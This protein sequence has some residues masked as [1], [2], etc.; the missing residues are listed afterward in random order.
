[1]HLLV[2]GQPTTFL[3]YNGGVCMPPLCP[4]PTPALH[5]AGGCPFYFSNVAPVP[6]PGCFMV[7][8]IGKAGSW[9]STQ[10]SRWV[11]SLEAAKLWAPVGAVRIANS[12]D[13]RKIC[14][15]LDTDGTRHKLGRGTPGGAS[16]CATADTPPA[17][18]VE[19]VVGFQV[20]CF[21]V[22]SVENPADQPSW[23]L[24]LAS[25]TIGVH[26]SCSLL[27]KW[28]QSCRTPWLT[29]GRP[30][31]GHYC[32]GATHEPDARQHVVVLR[33][34][35]CFGICYASFLYI[36]SLTAAGPRRPAPAVPYHPM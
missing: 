1:M 6:E 22:P 24:S 26:N 28:L 12:T 15:G 31:L 5:K 18:L 35:L 11:R 14:L 10:C 17:V 32:G 27:V 25:R 2:V 7:G 29:R 4:R 19:V 9:P 36:C 3:A 20:N 33:V 13:E 34:C 23:L 16:C 8:L 21:Q 30:F